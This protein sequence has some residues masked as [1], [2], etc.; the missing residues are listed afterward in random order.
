MHTCTTSCLCTYTRA[1][2]V[3][4]AARVAF[5]APSTAASVNLVMLHGQAAR[6]MTTRQ[7]RPAGHI[8][9]PRIVACI[10][11]ASRPTREGL[12]Q[13]RRKT[14]MVEW[15]ARRVAKGVAV[16]HR[17]AAAGGAWI[18]MA[19]LMRP[20]IPAVWRSRIV[21]RRYGCRSGHAQLCPAGGGAGPNIRSGYA[22]RHRLT[23]AVARYRPAIVDC[24]DF[25]AVGNIG[26]SAV[27][28]PR[29]FYAAGHH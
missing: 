23:T 2:S 16:L 13:T 6:S 25:L 9:Q 22:D 20:V 10:T 28:R 17:A 24:G 26:L 5:P 4:V 7:R 11:H 14:D 27:G 21:W 29:V 8:R 19:T 15:V 3:V 12:A 18:G 1:A